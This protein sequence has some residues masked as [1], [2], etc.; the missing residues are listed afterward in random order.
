M[1]DLNE[2]KSSDAPVSQAIPTH[3]SNRDRYR[4]LGLILM[5]FLILGVLGFFW[6]LHISGFEETEDAYITGHMHPV[7]ARVSGTVLQVLT[8]DNQTV[9]P[10]QLLVVIDPKNYQIALQQALHNLAV[11]KAQAETAKASI[12]YTQRQAAAQIAQAQA[13]IG[14][15]QST[16]SQSRQAAQEAQASI[17]A[18]TQALREQEAN[19]Q[20]AV[21]DYHRYAGADPEAISAQQLDTARTNLKIAE[22]N[23]AAARSQLTQVKSR[24]AQAITGIATSTNKVSESRGSFQGAKAQQ[25]QLEVVK[26]QAQSAVA[27]IATAQ[28]AVDQARL[29]LSYT[30][31]LAPIE[32]RVGRRTVEVGQQAPVG[33]PLMAIVSPSIWITANF[34]ETQ[35]KGIRPG[36]PVEISVDA[37]PNH[38]FKGYVDSFSPASGAEFALLPPENA[39]GNFT[40]TVQRVPVKIVFDPQSIRGYEQLLVPGLS[41]IPR[42]DISTSPKRHA[43]VR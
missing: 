16:V 20:K 15:S 30:R 28:D 35:L 29:N 27:A 7:S 33:E 39:S 43:A 26:A 18:A 13:G 10:N 8:D 1:S 11:A 4:T 19:Y 6:W 23:R 5:V 25:L 41:V 24:A 22:A 42:V 14:I 17:G 40:K 21:L 2:P 37:Y 38:T 32:G 12:P 9:K 36:Q 3:N 34:K 31:V